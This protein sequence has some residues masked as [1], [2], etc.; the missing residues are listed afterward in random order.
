MCTATTLRKK[1]F[2]FGRNL[3]LGGAHGEEVL[4]VPRS[5]PIPF[6]HF[7][8]EERHEALIG[9]GVVMDGF[10][11]FYDG[12]NESGL[13]VAGLNFPGNAVYGKPIEGKNNV[14]VFEFIPWL[15]LNAS[16]VQ[17]A[18]ILL[19]DT[20]LTDEAFAKGVP[21][22]TLHWMISDKESSI[23]VEST[24]TGLHVYDNPA[25]VMTNNPEF[26]IHLFMLNNYSN[27]SPKDKEP[28][29]GVD[30]DWNVYCKGLGGLGLPGDLS[31][32]SR[33]VKAAFTRANSVSADDEKSC[34]SQ[35]FHILG[36]VDQQRGAVI[37]GKGEYEITVYASCI[38]ASRGI[39]YYHTYDNRRVTKVDMYREDLEGDEISRFPLNTEEDILEAN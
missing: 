23:V 30:M 25:E 27:L 18:K 19:K 39:Y 38:N 11:L 1:D 31:S 13:A 29:F 26:P 24:S 12:A 37:Y 33:F 5:F 6:R 15:L 17:E 22:A 7:P 2:Y 32:I 9:M 14:A 28:T 4:V 20:Q 8:R 35:F 16:S 3:D 10:P 34:V 21:V 36:S